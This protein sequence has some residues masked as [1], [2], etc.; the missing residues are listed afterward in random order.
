MDVQRFALEGSDTPI[1]VFTMPDRRTAAQRPDKWILQ[2]QARRR[3]PPAAHPS[4]PLDVT[5]WLHGWVRCLRQVE[6]CLYGS[7]GGGAVYRLLQRESLSSCPLALRKGSVLAGHV[8]A[9]EYDQF[10]KELEAIS[11]LE[12]RG[13][14][15]GVTVLSL[16]VAIKLAHAI[17]RGTK[18]IAFLRAMQTPLPRLWEA[19]EEQDA[20]E[21]ELGGVDLALDHEI[22]E[23]EERKTATWPSSSWPRTCH[24]PLM[25]TMTSVR[26]RGASQ[27]CQQ[28]CKRSSTRS[29]ASAPT[30]SIASGMGRAASI[31]R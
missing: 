19:L 16:N 18:S 2:A 31:S 9:Q 8:T 23:L 30:Q 3:A 21:R 1:V 24:M 22:A 17:G 10:V 5:P 4:P 14:V 26:R 27:A 28:G 15:R 25:S 29:C 11:P 20:N 12:T 13:R 6:Q 7:T